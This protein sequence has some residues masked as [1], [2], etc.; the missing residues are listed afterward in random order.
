MKEIELT[1]GYVA[2]VDDEDYVRANSIRWHVHITNNNNMY[3]RNSDK[4]KWLHRFIMKDVADHL[5]VDH[6]D[7][8]GLNCQKHN[9]REATRSQNIFAR[10]CA[11]NRG[12]T[13]RERNAHRKWEA[14][15]KVMGKNKYLGSYYTEEEAREVYKKAALEHFG[16]FAN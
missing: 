12:V 16:D 4:T 9:L 5:D 10:Q 14:Q 8:N 13:Y 6:K 2:L 3:A 11:E 7:G 15:I 1:Q